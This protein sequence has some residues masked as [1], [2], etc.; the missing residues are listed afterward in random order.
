MDVEACVTYDRASIYSEEIG[1]VESQWLTWKMTRV[2][3]Y[4]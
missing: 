4:D 3:G 1:R 2:W